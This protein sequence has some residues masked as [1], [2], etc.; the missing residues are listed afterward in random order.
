MI[1]FFR[2]IRLKLLSQN[3]LGKYL[4]YAVGEIVLVMVGILLALQVNN[5]NEQRKNTIQ[6]EQIL[7]ELVIN[8]QTNLEE[9]ERNIKIQKNRIRHI[10]VLLD[11]IE[12]D[13]PYND[14]LS[15]RRLLYLEQITISTSAYQ[16]LKSIGL[17]NIQSESL[18]ME[19]I[20]LM[21]MTYPN[22]INLIR[23][24]SMQRYSVTR[25]VFNKF[26]RTN[27]E[28][29]AVPI[30]YEGLKQNQEFIN[31][32]YNRRAWKSGVIASNYRLIEPT[33][34]LIKNVNEYLGN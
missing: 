9:F 25:N 18:R 34:E 12:N 14:S 32:I 15:F 28:S 21:E 1:K 22:V 3:K 27:R 33:K 19:I 31:W 23:D 6:E 20:Q 4:L 29:V 7:K 8:L 24:V 16:S 11:H 13:K 30:D 5:W 17:K 2:K 10:D 26:F